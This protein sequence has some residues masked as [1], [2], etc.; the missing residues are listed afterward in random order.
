MTSESTLIEAS[1]FPRLIVRTGGR[2]VREVELRSELRIGRAEDNDLQLPDPK[3]S[4][5]HARL[6]PEAGVFVLTDLGSANGTRVNGL[7]I[8]EPHQLA[9]G[10]RITIGDTELAYQE[11]GRSEQDTVT[12]ESAAAAIPGARPLVA[13]LEAPTPS[14]K[15]TSRGLL[16]GLI[17]AASVLVVGI[18]VIVVFLLRPGQPPSPTP[19]SMAAHVTT[20]VAAVTSAVT[21]G[22]TIVTATP[23]IGGVDAQEMDDL[24]TQGEALTR[25]SKFEDAIAIYQD[26]V[27]RASDDARPEIGWAWALVLDEQAT[28]ALAHAQRAVELDPISPAAAAVL[29]RVYVELEDK[30]Q[31]L[32]WAQ[33]AV[34]LDSANAEAH[35][36]LAEAYLLNG[37]TQ[38]AVDEA[39]LALV[40]DINNADA[41]R[42][43]GW[44]YYA[45]DNDMGRAA[46]ELQIAAGLQPEL[47]LRRH[48]LGE[49]LLDAED[50]VTAIMAFQDALAIR[51]KAVTY[52]AIGE[53]YYRLGQYDQAR[54]SLQQAIASGADDA[55]TYALLG[56]SYAQ[57]DRCDEARNYY[58]QALTLESANPL[59][60]EAEAL[61]QE[62]GPSPT[63]SATI[64]AVLEPTAVVEPTTV[65]APEATPQPTRSSPSAAR[66]SGQIAFPVWN[67]NNAKYDTYL[68]NVDGSGRRLVAEKMHQ[69]ALRPDGSWLAINGERENYQHLCLMQPNGSNLREITDFLEDGQPNWSPDENRLVF[70]STRHGD[71]QYR[72]YIVDD[73]PF[74]GGKVE[75]RTL[76][77]GPDDVRGQMPAWTA[78]GRIVYR[79]CDLES[80]ANECNG[81][82]LYIVSAVPGPQTPKRLTQHPED[83]APSVYGSTIAF[84]SNRD[85]TW[86]IYS[87]GLDG[88]G[89]KRLTN[90]AAHD[91]LPV[92]SPDGK[93]IAFVSDQGGPWAVWAMSP[94]GSNLRKL[95]A[96][97]DGGLSFDW[98]HERISWGR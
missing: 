51:P 22:P 93:T 85:G 30:T 80:P 82:G 84:M 73:V 6:A 56:A 70:A 11:P 29:A 32:T 9:H 39:D 33:K 14:E 78:D 34:E 53:A 55:D 60:L 1:L 31:A 75:G 12:M 79:G 27:T 48:E 26:L 24:L 97:G 61:C 4:R 13:P 36:V 86:E 74:G 35:T 16:V 66:L 76:N 25:R 37:Q 5:H 50:Y 18:V 67:A 28:E 17:L 64:A 65:S 15:G 45:M 81:T 46:S 59:A 7:R 40:Q 57:L 8:T 2:V 77:Y 88:S 71:K 63:P 41:H 62:G 47:W 68:V 87:M 49:L 98:Q 54:A 3:A 38:E 90:N 91:G 89:L 23:T 72:I 42:I 52:T 69:P 83:T 20:S 19:T 95:F 92:W 43:R 94:D 58:E 44:L 96:I 10:D 21:P